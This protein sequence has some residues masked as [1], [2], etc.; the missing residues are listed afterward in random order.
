M[1]A[2]ILYEVSR[3]TGPSYEF[4]KS[5]DSLG[6][7]AVDALLNL[8]GTSNV[9]H[10]IHIILLLGRTKDPR[11]VEPLIE[12]LQHENP[13][14]RR[15]SASSLNSFSDPRVVKALNLALDDQDDKVREDAKKSLE[16]IA[17]WGK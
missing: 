16:W 7:I 15:F 11:A 6:P 8:L 10:M 17:R 3:S 13:R 12:L 2:L 1:E 5:I 4:S 14:V 9:D